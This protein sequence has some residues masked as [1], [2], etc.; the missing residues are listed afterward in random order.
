MEIRIAHRFSGNLK[1]SYVSTY[2]V[3]NKVELDQ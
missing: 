3:L 1:K 2:K